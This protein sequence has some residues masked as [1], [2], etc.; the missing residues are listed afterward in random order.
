[1]G[2]LQFPKLV[3]WCDGA[4]AKKIFITTVSCLMLMFAWAEAGHARTT[5][6]CNLEIIFVSEQ[7]HWDDGWRDHNPPLRLNAGNLKFSA[8]APGVSHNKAR[9]RASKKADKCVEDWWSRDCLA[10]ES[11][12]Y[13]S[14]YRRTEI[15]ELMNRRICRDLR[16]QR[17]TDLLGHQLRG[18]LYGKIDGDRCCRD[19]SREC[20]YKYGQTRTIGLNTGGLAGRQ[21]R[22]G[23][24]YYVTCD[25]DSP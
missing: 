10:A 14:A 22:D 21:L 4:Y 18:T 19:S 23:E 8:S 2:Y 3:E 15:D 6:S 1:M 5:R 9:M 13:G 16:R 25:P 7:F 17:R 12:N 20:P 24:T 11:T